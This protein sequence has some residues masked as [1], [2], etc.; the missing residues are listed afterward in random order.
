MCRPASSSGRLASTAASTTL[1]MIDDAALQA[2]L[3]ARD[4]REVEE[5]VDDPHQLPHLPVHDGM[6]RS[7]VRVVLLQLQQVQGV[8]QRSQRIAQLV[9]EGREELIAARFGWLA[10]LIG[11][12]TIRPGLAPR[13]PDLPSAT[14]ALGARRLR[15][16]VAG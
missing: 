11:C 7:H 8:A 5:V 1:A 4:A 2:D 13:R 3:A 6:D 14:W 12:A 16:G 10:V 15:P 9:R